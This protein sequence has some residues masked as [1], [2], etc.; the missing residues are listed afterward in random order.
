MSSLKGFLVVGMNSSTNK[1]FE[2]VWNLVCDFFFLCNLS[3]LWY[4]I[5]L[6]RN[7]ICACHVLMLEANNDVYEEVV[8]PLLEEVRP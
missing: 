4:Y 6:P 7:Y 8:K 2:S 1:L 3:L 5:I